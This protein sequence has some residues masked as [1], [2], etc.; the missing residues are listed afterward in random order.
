MCVCVCVCVCIHRQA[1]LSMEFPITGDLPDPG[2][3]P[4]SLASPA[5][6]G[7]FFTT[8]PLQKPIYVYNDIYKR[9]FILGI[10][11]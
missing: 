6:A 10:G 11:S 1:P 3:E 9:R 4:T 2:F 8:E 5:L 7:G